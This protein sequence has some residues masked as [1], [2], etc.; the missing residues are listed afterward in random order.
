MNLIARFLFEN[1]PWSPFWSAFAVGFCIVGT[2]GIVY[3]T[4]AGEEYLE[5]L[6]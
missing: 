4:D 3:L 5:T 1:S 6:E 2:D